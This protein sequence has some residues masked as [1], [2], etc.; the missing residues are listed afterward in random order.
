MMGGSVAAQRI[1]RIYA[2]ATGKPTASRTGG[3]DR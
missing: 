3:S 2:T 1:Y